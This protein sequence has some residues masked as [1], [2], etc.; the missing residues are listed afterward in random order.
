MEFQRSRVVPVGI[1]FARP[2]ALF[3]DAPLHGGELTIG[4]VVRR[5]SCGHAFKRFAGDIHLE[6]ASGIVV[7]QIDALPRH[8]FDDKLGRK[9]D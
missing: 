9:D 6:R 5:E 8:D 7:H 4:R 3:V 1:A 2:F